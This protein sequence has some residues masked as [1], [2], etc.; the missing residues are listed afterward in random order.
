MRRVPVAPRKH[1]GF[2]GLEERQSIG[3]YVR[4]Q[5]GVG[6]ALSSNKYKYE[7]KEEMIPF[8]RRA[9]TACFL[10]LSLTNVNFKFKLG[11]IPCSSELIRSTSLVT[12]CCDIFSF[13]ST[14]LY[15]SMVGEKESRRA[16]YAPSRACT[17]FSASSSS[18]RSELIFILIVAFV[19][20]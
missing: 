16:N 6:T 8:P 2:G 1:F 14:L 19:V 17:A 18:S 4:K 11:C 15:L 3:Q 20:T 10:I 13:P 12:V 7:R 9:P 5:I